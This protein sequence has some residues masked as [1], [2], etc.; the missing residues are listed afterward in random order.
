MFLQFILKKGLVTE[1]VYG[2]TVLMCKWNKATLYG[3]R[4]AILKA[5]H[6]SWKPHFRFSQPLHLFH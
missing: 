3:V 1:S 4:I 5:G 2:G 6:S